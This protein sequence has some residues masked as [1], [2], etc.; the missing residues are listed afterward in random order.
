MYLSFIDV[1]VVVIIILLVLVV[2]FIS[3]ALLRT[4]FYKNPYIKAI[5]KPNLSSGKIDEYQKSLETMLTNR[6][7]KALLDLFPNAMIKGK[8]VYFKSGLMY[9]YRNNEIDAMNILV[10]VPLKSLDPNEVEFDNQFIIGNNTYRSKTELYT[11]MDAIE[12][13]LQDDGDLKLNIRVLMY[14]RSQTNNEMITYLFD[15]GIKFDLIIGEGGKILDPL[16]TNLPSYYSFSGVGVNEK[17]TYK[18]KTKKQAKGNLRLSAFIGE[19]LND[20][21]FNLKS[22]KELL[23]FALFVGKD[24]SFGN[25]FIINNILW[26]PKVGEKLIDDEIKFISSAWRTY[27]VFD[28]LYSSE[29]ECY[30]YC[31]FYLANSE[32]IDDVNLAISKLLTKYGVEFEVVSSS[33]K[34]RITNIRS[35][36][37]KR[38]TDVVDRTITDTYFTPYIINSDVSDRDIEKLGRCV[39]RFSPLYYP[40]EVLDG[41]S[42]K[43]MVSYTS[44]DRAINF[45]EEL[46]KEF[47]KYDGKY[48]KEQI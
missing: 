13:T 17:V 16:S 27:F 28:E 41:E 20:N 35:R 46:I 36:N 4:T 11:I 34:T 8:L 9:I 10:D 25:R 5:R 45:Y 38:F 12:T 37:F 29:D 1:F 30:I 40:K 21:L 24:M 3:F 7:D 6:L 14:D 22:N 23:K 2:A 19:M 15:K 47:S 39:I 42:E 18:F 33:E 31:D 44:I 26:L 48:T 43:E 32:T